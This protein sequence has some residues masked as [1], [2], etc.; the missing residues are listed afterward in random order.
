M[1]PKLDVKFISFWLDLLSHLLLLPQEKC[2][3]VIKKTKKAHKTK[4]NKQT[5]KQKQTSNV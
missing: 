1:Q 5:Q 2:S 3:D 4:K